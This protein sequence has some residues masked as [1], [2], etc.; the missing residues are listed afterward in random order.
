MVN[1]HGWDCFEPARK[2]T[3][4][5]YEFWREILAASP[6][7]K[8]RSLDSSIGQ[9]PDEERLVPHGLHLTDPEEF[10]KV[11]S[12]DATLSPEGLLVAWAARME[13]EEDEEQSQ[14]ESGLS[15][16][17][18][19][20]YDADGNW[21]RVE[22]GFTEELRAAPKP[23]YEAPE[24]E[25]ISFPLPTREGKSFFTS[26]HEPCCGKE[27]CQAKGAAPEGWRPVRTH[28]PV[29]EYRV[30]WDEVRGCK[31]PRRVLVKTLAPPKP[32]EKPS[33]S[34]LRTQ[35][36]RTQSSSSGGGGGAGRSRAQA[37]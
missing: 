25:P 23:A 2:H 27:C 1:S 3:R 21:V 9:D 30:H 33:K 19:H 4:G 32:G 6:K 16:E 13:V 12:L 8:A 14:R 17:C 15:P 36:S 35:D 10:P 26:S 22:A 7:A 18:Y 31:D 28:A 29:V 11:E 24:E 20:A 34:P 37:L 5:A